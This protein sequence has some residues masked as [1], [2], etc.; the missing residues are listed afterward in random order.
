MS[1]EASINQVP[2]EDLTPEQA[3]HIIHSHRKVRYEESEPMEMSRYVGQNSIPALLRDQPSPIE[4]KDGIDIRR[5]M[6][7]IFGLENSA[8]FP[9]MS[10]RHLERMTQDIFSELPSDREVMK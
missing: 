10:P 4:T 2:I 7:P 5:D 6:R 9:L 1:P 3:S 8:P